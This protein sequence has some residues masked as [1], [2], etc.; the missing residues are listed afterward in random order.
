MP[1]SGYLEC[2]DKYK[3]K[4]R[5]REARGGA[6]D[7]GPQ[8]CSDPGS[9]ERSS[10]RLFRL[11]RR[12]RAKRPVLVVPVSTFA[13]F[14]FAKVNFQRHS[15]PLPSQYRSSRYPQVRQRK[16]RPQ[17]RGV[18]EPS[19]GPRF[20]VTNLAFHHASRVLN[21]GLRVLEPRCHHAS[22]AEQIG[23]SR[24]ES[25]LWMKSEHEGLAHVRPA[26][27]VEDISGHIR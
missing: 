25:Y 16:Q 14:A 3:H 19:V 5:R 9:F 4:E 10:M 7:D 1:T 23:A 13:S 18:L 12:R 27:Y 21:L 22:D 11:S 6:L 2:P 20:R 26:A 8:G 15:A 24:D 17:L